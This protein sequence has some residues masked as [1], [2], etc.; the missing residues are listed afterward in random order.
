[1]AIDREAERS[2]RAS[3]HLGSIGDRYILDRREES[4]LCAAPFG[5]RGPVSGFG[6]ARLKPRRHREANGSVKCS[7]GSGFVHG[8]VVLGAIA[9]FGRHTRTYTARPRM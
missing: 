2:P 6:P 5:S 1:M 7:C 4:L 8:S 9:V 3:T